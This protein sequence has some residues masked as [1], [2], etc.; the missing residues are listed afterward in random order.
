MVEQT[1]ELLASI[2]FS[3]VFHN[4]MDPVLLVSKGRFIEC[5]QAAIT[6]MKASTREDII[7]RR[8]TDLSPEYQ[9]DGELSRDKAGRAAGEATQSSTHRFEWVHQDMNGEAL[10]VEVTLTKT[11]GYTSSPLVVTWRDLAQARKAEEELR[12]SRELL[13]RTFQSLTDALFIMD[14][15][16]RILA[17]NSAASDIFGYSREEMLGQRTTFLHVDRTAGQR[18]PKVPPSRH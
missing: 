4:S 14:E 2:P 6:I 15:K 12:A 16:G 3:T 1:E 7:G 8:P 11:Q 10:W 9:P 17:C 5:N 13:T 18:L